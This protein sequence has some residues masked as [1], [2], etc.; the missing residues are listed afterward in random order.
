MK[1]LTWKLVL[2]LTIISFATFT[3][4]WYILPVDA[5]DTMMTGFPL[6]YLCSGW[7]TSLSLQVFMTEFMI[8]LLA[9]FAFWFLL[10]FMIDRFLTRIRIH[11]ILTIA[12][13]TLS[14]LFISG[15]ILIASNSDNIFHTKF[16][17]N[18]SDKYISDVLQKYHQPNLSG[19][20]LR[21]IVLPETT[22]FHKEIQEYLKSL[23]SFTS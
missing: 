1:Q 8:D 11:K 17:R 22:K 16:T 10:I 5:P 14:G 9:Y 23:I 2:P 4:W 21:N 19:K 3:K 18:T 20:Q 13:L 7:H 6:P 12:L 15:A